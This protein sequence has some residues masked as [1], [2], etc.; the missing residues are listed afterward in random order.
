[1]RVSRARPSVAGAAFEALARFSIRFRWAIVVAWIV[2]MAR[3][4][5]R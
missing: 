1:M 3:S 5:S 4:D 2:V